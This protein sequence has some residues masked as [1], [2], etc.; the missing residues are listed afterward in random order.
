[1]N[2]DRG[3]G[4][5]PKGERAASERWSFQ[6]E[7]STEEECEEEV[8][9]VKDHELFSGVA[10][11]Y[12]NSKLSDIN[13]S[14]GTQTYPAHKFLLSCVSPVFKQMLDNANNWEE[15][16]GT[17]IV[18]KELP[19]CE[20]TF[21]Q[22]LQFIYSRRVLLSAVTVKPLFLLADKY[23]ISSLQELCSDF[24]R[25]HLSAHT[26][27]DVMSFAHKYHNQELSDRCLKYV[28]ENAEE[29]MY[30]PG[31]SEVDQDILILIVQRDDLQIWNE[32]ELFS[33]VLRWVMGDS[34]RDALVPQIFHLLR[35]PLIC[36]ELLIHL[37][38]PNVIFQR[39]PE[40]QYL[41]TEAYKYQLLPEDQREKYFGNNVRCRP[42]QYNFIELG[43]YAYCVKNYSKIKHLTRLKT[44]TFT[45]LACIGG[46]GVA[47]PTARPDNAPP[48]PR[49]NAPPP[50]RPEPTLPDVIPRWSWTLW[51]EPKGDADLPSDRTFSEEI[52][53]KFGLFLM[54]VKSTDAEFEQRE[55]DC[56]FVVFGRDAEGQP[57]GHSLRDSYVYMSNNCIGF[58]EPDLLKDENNSQSYIHNDEIDILVLIGYKPKRGIESSSP[59][60]PI[61][62]S[63]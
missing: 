8:Y 19:E 47:A 63:Q 50:T 46:D 24:F 17:A 35:F 1:M 9:S 2:T 38:E 40:I 16:R 54:P 15:S 49:P 18:L 21:P 59:P 7:S 39:C 51:V 33:A 22:F 42:R 58:G 41:L 11:F 5:I 29:V 20:E 56:V 31:W 28:A 60:P 48:A 37:V 27:L 13:L 25:R 3:N 61:T 6:M 14:V 43:R 55:V 23:A 44:E 12:N 30:T 32:I 52:T 57:T 34:S 36:Y 26:V 53:R 4:G 10:D 62:T 45:T